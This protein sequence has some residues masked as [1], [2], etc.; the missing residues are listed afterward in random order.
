MSSPTP[1][2]PTLDP[3]L[4]EDWDDEDD[5][6]WKAPLDALIKN[7]QSPREA[8]QAMDSLLR[9][10]ASERLQKLVEYANT[11]DMNTEERETGD[12]GGLPP[13]NSGAMAEQ[14]LGWCARVCTAYAPYSEGQNRLIE[15]LEELRS[16]PRWMAPEGRPDENGDVYESEFW[17]FGRGWIALDDAF[18]RQHVGDLSLFVMACDKD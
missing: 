2:S 9:T 1:A 3:E 7:T 12:W 8:A 13:P 5:L 16:L 14:V 18:R 11:H 17:K 4:F 15:L 10:E 6:R